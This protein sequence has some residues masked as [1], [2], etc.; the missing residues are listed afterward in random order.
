MEKNN[1]RQQILD[2]AL[3]LF[4]V[5]GYE[6]ASISQIAD[7]VG[8]RKASLYSHFENKQ[9]ILDS[10]ISCATEQY[11]SKSLVAKPQ[12]PGTPEQISEQIKEQVRYLVHDPEMSRVRK[13]LV[14]EQ[15][16]NPEMAAILTRRNYTDV[17]AYNIASMEALIAT[18]ML[19]D[20]DPEIMAAEFCLPINAWISI[21][22]RSPERENEMMELIEKHVLQFF[23]VY[24]RKK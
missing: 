16:R 23:K 22:D 8:L 20:A 3:D 1:T 13:L 4:S 14:I 12:T 21:C 17:M 11:E 6:A 15:F 24:G 9:D 10:I 18:G 7:A 2:A 19:E 5:Q